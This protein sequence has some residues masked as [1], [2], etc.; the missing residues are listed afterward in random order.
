MAF[1]ELL[2]VIFI[3]IIEGITEWLPISSTGHMLLV[4][5]FLKLQADAEFKEMLLFSLAQLSRL[6]ICIGQSCGHSDLPAVM[7]Q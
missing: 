2:K 7:L 3:G 5:Q 4:D 1:I 6:F